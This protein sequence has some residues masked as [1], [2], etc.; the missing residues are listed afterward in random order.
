E[1][2]NILEGQFVNR[3][4]DTIVNDNDKYRYKNPAPLYTIGITSSLNV[5]HFNF[6][7]GARANLGQYV[8]NNV[9]TDMGY[10]KRLYGSSKYLSNVNQSAVDLNVEDQANLTFS[11]HF[12]TEASFFRVDHITLGYSFDHLIGK[13]LNLYTTVQNPFVITKYKGLDPE[14]GNGIDNQIYP[15]PRTYVLGLNVNF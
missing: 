10:L 12:I 2:G 4:G 6:S 13:Y 11:D 3:N 5:G 14:I 8:Y 9:Q 7:F 15:R 1:S